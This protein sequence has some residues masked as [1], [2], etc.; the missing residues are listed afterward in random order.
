MKP[1]DFKRY[2]QR[3]R[4]KARSLRMARA[5]LIDGLTQAEASRQEGAGREAARRAVDRIL[6][7]QRKEI[8]ALDHWV[9]IT[10][11]VPPDAADKVRLI[12]KRERAKAGL[13]P[14]K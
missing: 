5:V 10:V 1:D 12:E 2:A 3:T 4:L 11:T 14:P 7:E 6:G 13:R 8:G 9:T